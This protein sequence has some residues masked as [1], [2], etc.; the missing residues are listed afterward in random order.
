MTK[1][2][3][4]KQIEEVRRR[5]QKAER[6]LLLNGRGHPVYNEAEVELTLEEYQHE[7]SSTRSEERLMEM[8]DEERRRYTHTITFF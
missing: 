8:L 7:G 6:Q 5:R 4:I 2:Q 3:I 1:D